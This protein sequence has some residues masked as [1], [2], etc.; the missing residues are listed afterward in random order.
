MGESG[1]RTERDSGS[2][3]TFPTT[4]IISFVRS[5]GSTGSPPACPKRS[6]SRRSRTT[7]SARSRPDSPAMASLDDPVYE[8][9]HSERSARIVC[10]WLRSQGADDGLVREVEQRS[11]GT[12]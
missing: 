7:W 2:S 4:G 9:L 11:S 10:D 3:K 6:G 5:N 8:R 1:L 12:R